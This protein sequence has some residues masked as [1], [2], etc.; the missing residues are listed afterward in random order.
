MSREEKHSAQTEVVRGGILKE[1]NLSSKGK[2][3][4]RI[5][6]GQDIEAIHRGK[7]QPNM[8]IELI[9]LP[10]LLGHKARERDWKR[11]VWKGS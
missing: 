3:G 5:G 10:Q 9:P 11:R 1:V 7:T 6:I 8:S 4:K 2:T